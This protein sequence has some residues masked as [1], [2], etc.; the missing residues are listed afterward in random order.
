MHVKYK[1][2]VPNKDGQHSY[3]DLVMCVMVYQS[4]LYYF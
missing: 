2:D 3:A 4:G 1:I